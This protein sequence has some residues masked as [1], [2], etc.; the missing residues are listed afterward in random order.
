MHQQSL[1]AGILLI[2]S[3]FV[4][5]PAASLSA[6]V[7]WSDEFD[8]PAIDRSIWTYDIGGWGWGNGE[9][10]FYTSR[11]ENAYIE[12]G[13]LVIQALRENYGG[14]SFTSAR[15][16]TQGRFAFKYGTLEARIKM[17]DLANGLWPAFWLLGNNFG[18]ADWPVCGEIDIVELGS[19]AAI[20]AGLTNRKLNAAIHWDNDGEYLYNSLFIDAPVDLNLDYH[21]YKLSWTPTLITAYLDDVPFWSFDISD[22]EANFLTEFHQPAFMIMNIAIG[23]WNYVKINDPAGITAPFPAKMMVDWIRLTANEHTELVFGEDIEERGNF[24]VFTDTTPVD[25]HLVYGTDADLYLWNNMTATETT[26]YE[27]GDAW[28]FDAAPGAWYGMGV[29]TRQNRNMTNYSDGYLRFHMKTT[30]TETIKVGIK[31]AVGSEFWLPL[32]PGVQEFGLVR[33]GEWHEVAIP[34]NRFADIDFKSVHQMLMIAGDP[35][36]APVN[37]SIDNVYWEE[38]VPRPTPENGSFGVY[39]ETA[40][41]KDAGEFA[42]GDEGDFFVWENTLIAAPEN[43]YEGSGSLSLTS[44]TGMTWFGAAFT[45]NVKFNLTA[46]RYPESKLRFAMKTSSSVTFQVGMKSGNIDGI[47]QKWITFRSGS[48][49]Y[50]FVRDGNW[51][52][53]EIP[54]TDIT[55]SVDLAEVSQLFQIL[56]T[57]GPITGIEL[58]DIC[59]IGGG[60]AESGSNSAP[61][62]SITSPDAGQFF[63]VGDDI[64][65]EAAASDVDGT[66]VKVEF[67][68][69]A[70]LLGEDT[71]EPYSMTVNDVPG[72]A[73]TFSAK[74]TNSNDLSRSASVTVY[75][76]T[77]ELATLAVSPS[78]TAVEVGQT[79]P[80]T[81]VAKDQFGLPFAV[82]TDWSVSGGGSIDAAGLFTAA[83]PG[84]FTVTAQAGSLSKT[85]TVTVT[86]PLGSC[87]GGPANGDYTYIVS[88]DSQNPTVTFVP[89]YAGVGAGTLILY[90]STASGGVYPGYM[91]T[92]NTAY[93]VTAANGQTLYFY[94]TYSIPEGGQRST[95]DAKHSV[96]VGNCAVSTAGDINGDG[97]ITINDILMLAYYWLDTACSGDNAFC[98]GADTQPDG[99]VNLLDLAYIARYWLN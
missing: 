85:A 67:F 23:G 81:A 22:P 52:V 40:A 43:P 63:A 1:K 47:G 95:V 80:F 70:T 83:F 74:A 31:S 7:I 6:Q 2:L 42:F 71:T 51:H 87:T 82:D 72:G 26:A 98:Q 20:Q 97:E 32:T 33:D 19:D 39:T 4:F 18:P 78:S 10:Q 55:D 61:S 13:N 64:T 14:R 27:G 15:L 50:G 34:L 56:G 92:P 79:K 84:T 69:G 96:V 16:L 57:S 3:L 46:F 65:I 17:P 59:F 73:Y 68:Q 48:D 60:Q 53:V 37:L 90:Y 94:Y 77:P 5:Q 75:V 76:G 86:R 93:P 9:L 88:G 54:M 24:G 12:D 99:I 11:P 36:A 21:R 44:A 29:L 8:G 38:S 25:A 89:G 41:H 91:T 49:P 58:D 28:S 45:P 30:T 62:V 35:P 66:I